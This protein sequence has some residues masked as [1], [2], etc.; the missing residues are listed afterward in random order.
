M[1]Q[2]PIPRQI[3][4]FEFKLIGFL[5]IK[6]FIYLA[7][8]VLLGIIVYTIFPIP[9]VN[10]LLAALVIGAGVALAFLPINDRPLDVWLKNLLKR[11]TSPTQYQFK[12]HNAIPSFF[13]NMI[14]TSSAT[15]ATSHIDAQK[16][17]TNYLGKGNGAPVDNK[18]QTIHDLMQS[19]STEFSPKK[20]DI[21]KAEK[22]EVSNPLPPSPQRKIF[23]SGMIKNHKEI[24]LYGVLIYVKK[25]QS[26]EPIRILKTN[27]N[28]VFATFSPLPAGEY[29]FEIKDPQGTHFF[30]TIK[31]KVENVNPKPFEFFS[32]ELI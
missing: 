17:L 26:S 31:V 25:D 24:P 15:T 4:T 3:T 10:I 30:D 19:K 12:K 1:D 28:G 9:I 11:L 14:M 6:Q 16:K 18:K 27:I 13:K 7:V 21:K 2:H 20:V 29:F 5:T 8:F 32:K 23:F 22:K